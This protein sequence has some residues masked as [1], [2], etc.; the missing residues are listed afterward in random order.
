M[1]DNLTLNEL[2]ALSALI[3]KDM[4]GLEIM[5][6]INQ[7]DEVKKAMYLG[8]LYNLMNRLEK[9]G[10]TE[11]Y[12]GEETSERGGNRRRYYKITGAGEM[13]LKKEQLTLTKLWGLEVAFGIV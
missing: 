12:W 8:S 11:S 10:F 7:D 2:K 6:T 1:K 5:K 3:R 9:K 13:A 4:Y